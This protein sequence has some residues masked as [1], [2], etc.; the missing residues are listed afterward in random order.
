MIGSVESREVNATSAYVA[1][2]VEENDLPEKLFL[3]HQFTSGMIE[4]KELVKPR[5][6]LAMTFNVDGFGDQSNKLS[7]WDLF[8]K[9]KPHLNDAYKLF[10]KEDV[11]LMTPREVLSMRPSPDLVV[12][13]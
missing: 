4:N 6:G 5:E 2:I 8:T 7:K 3:V 12:Y 9:Q 1:Q 13:E 10:Y 11:N